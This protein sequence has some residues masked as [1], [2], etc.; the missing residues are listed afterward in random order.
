MP[1]ADCPREVS[2][3]LEI[4]GLKFLR[5]SDHPLLLCMTGWFEFTAPPEFR[6][7]IITE[8]GSAYFEDPRRFGKVHAVSA[9]QQQAILAKILFDIF[10][11]VEAK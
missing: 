9:A 8:D 1:C 3:R 11:V 10:A 4:K 6:M 5:F 2:Q 7:A